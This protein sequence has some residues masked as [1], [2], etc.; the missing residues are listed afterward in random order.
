MFTLWQTG[1]HRERLR[2]GSM[3]PRLPVARDLTRRSGRRLIFRMP[4]RLRESRAWDHFAS[5]VVVEPGFS[6][7]EAGRERMPCRMKM[8]RGVLAGRTI[9]TTDVPAFSTPPQVQPPPARR[10]AI[11][12][13]I[14]ARRHIRVD[15]MALGFHR[16]SFSDARPYGTSNILP[17]LPFAKAACA[18]AASRSGTLLPIGIVSLCAAT[19]S[20]MYFKFLVSCLDTKATVRT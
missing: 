17:A 8:L 6:G 15:S 19:A 7:L 13:A 11:C 16:R 5:S 20:T 4:P 3:E 12:A 10:E 18:S 1:W 9:A 2:R 14:A